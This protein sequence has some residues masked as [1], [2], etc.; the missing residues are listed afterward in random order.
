LFDCKKHIFYSENLKIKDFEL[1][2]NFESYASEH[3][4][5]DCKKYVF[6]SE[7]LPPLGYDGSIAYPRFDRKRV[8]SFGS[9]RV[10]PAKIKDS[11]RLRSKRLRKERPQARADETH[12][13]NMKRILKRPLLNILENH[14]IA[15]PTPSNISYL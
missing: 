4:V 7:N 15:Y 10:P 6:Y 1:Q 3:G 14:A 8:R 13:T 9:Q 5:F 11:S 12:K 2:G